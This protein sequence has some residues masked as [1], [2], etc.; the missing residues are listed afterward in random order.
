MVIGVHAPEFAFEKDPQNVTQAV[1]DLGVDYPVALDNDYAIWKAFG[2]E[3]WRGLIASECQSH[4]P[5]TAEP[6]A[7]W[8]GSAGPSPRVAGP[9]L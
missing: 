7:R 4:M 9:G 5:S 6:G 8:Q 2:N 1:K 3:Y